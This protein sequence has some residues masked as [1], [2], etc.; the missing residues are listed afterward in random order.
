M[1]GHL[2][3]SNGAEMYVRVGPANGVHHVLNCADRDINSETKS[4]QRSSAT[5]P[6]TFFVDAVPES[7]AEFDVEIM[8]LGDTSTNSLAQTITMVG[9]LYDLP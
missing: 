4:I 3:M 2:V 1:T 8:R 6:M 7:N 5:Q 9:R